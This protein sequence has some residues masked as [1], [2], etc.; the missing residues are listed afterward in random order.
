VLE[1]DTG[2]GLKPPGVADKKGVDCFPAERNELQAF[3]THPRL[4]HRS[5]SC[6]SLADGSAGDVLKIRNK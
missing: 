6:G 2:E 1:S 4:G 3:G 5:L